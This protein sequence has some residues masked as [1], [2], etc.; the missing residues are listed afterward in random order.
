VL[1]EKIGPAGAIVARVAGVA[2]VIR[3]I[4]LIAG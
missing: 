1:I 2:I 4:Q 3:G